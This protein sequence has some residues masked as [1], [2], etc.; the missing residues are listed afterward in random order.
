ME[1]RGVPVALRDGLARYFEDGIRPG[2]FLEAVL[3]GDLFEAFKRGDPE[4]LAQ[5]RSVVIFLHND[6]PM[7]SF[8]NK[9]AVDSWIARHHPP[10][11]P[12][13]LDGE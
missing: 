11:E 9:C 6:V 13:F 2:Q 5:L 3:A 10:T 8:G 12:W 7:G 1:K 4:T